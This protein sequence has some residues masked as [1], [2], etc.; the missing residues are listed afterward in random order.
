MAR[1]PTQDNF[2]VAPSGP[3]GARFDPPST[4]GMDAPA[5]QLQQFGQAT[6]QLGGAMADI[7]IDAA[8]EAN[9]L[10]VLEAENEA[11]QAILDLTY[12][13]QQGYT[14]AKGRDVMFRDSGKP[15]ADEYDGKLRERFDQIGSGLSNDAQRQMFEQ[16]AMRLRSSFAAQTTQYEAAEYRGYQQSVVKGTADLSV[17]TIARN[18]R[19]FDVIDD[20]LNNRLAPSIHQLGRMQGL[21]GNEITALSNVAKSRALVGAISSAI[22]S[23]DITTASALFDRY[24]SDLQ[25]ADRVKVEGVIR[26]ETQGRV[27]MGA[28]DAAMGDA[29]AVEGHGMP[30]IGGRVTSRFGEKRGNEVHNGVDIAV[31]V[32]TPVRAPAGGEVVKVW[33]DA[34]NGKAVRIRFPDGSV[35]GFA[36]LSDQK[37]KVGD[38][39]A[40]GQVFALSGNTGRSTGPHLHYKLEKDGRAVDPLAPGSA[41]TKPATLEDA[42]AQTRARLP[43]D[44]STDLI[45]AARSEL[46]A[47]WQMK[48]AS[49]R[50]REDKAM[51]GVYTALI[52]NGG[53]IAALPARVRAAIPA[54]KYDSAIS[55]ANTIRTSG[56]QTDEVAYATL[57]SSPELLSSLSDSQFLSLRPKLSQSDFKHFA[58]QRAELR[59]GGTKNAP[60]SLNNAAI[61]RTVD[62][63]L[64]SLGIDPLPKTDDTAAMA[65]VGAVR[66]FVN[67]AIAEEQQRTGKQM[68]DV[69]VEQFIDRQF[70]RAVPMRNSLWGTAQPA[71]P[72]LSLGVDEISDDTRAQIEGTLKSRGVPIT[73]DSILSMYYAMG[74]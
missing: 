11:R 13:P 17:E 8:R 60:G 49:D 6:E 70:T 48:E 21:S 7:A 28:V 66:R 45:K 14:Q 31:P 5:R 72:R 37:V 46:A 74:E 26:R 9:Q 20:E 10:R 41:T 69:E 27:V 59:G 16:Q 50:D 24:G 25:E 15:L 2:Q 68:N 44:A 36:H 56:D 40:A 4:A 18:A 63:R 65:R 19:N 42:W 54:D 67:N 43:A 3:T 29:Q 71:R 35:G 33:E 38:K 32:G 22:D 1:V 23:E 34:S 51:T 62:T 57:A 52:Q 53:D 39:V 58:N 55:F 64:S 73:D 30:V 61:K 12:D 47:R